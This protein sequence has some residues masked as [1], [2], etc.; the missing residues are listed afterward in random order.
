MNPALCVSSSMLL[1]IMWQVPAHPARYNTQAGE[2]LGRE[3]VCDSC[4]HIHRPHREREHSEQ[5]CFEN[6]EFPYE[7]MS[8][9]VF[10]EAQ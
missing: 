4:P 6:R 5:H 2:Q 7:L 10:I 3:P 8:T 9:L 1:R